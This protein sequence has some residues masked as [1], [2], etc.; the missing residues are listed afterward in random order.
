M[1]FRGCPRAPRE[2]VAAL[3]LSPTKPPIRLAVVHGPPGMTEARAAQVQH[4]ERPVGMGKGVAQGQSRA[5][6]VAGDQ[7]LLVAE[8]AP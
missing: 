3:A 5:P 8:V 7:P 1:L 4:T 6:G 2:R